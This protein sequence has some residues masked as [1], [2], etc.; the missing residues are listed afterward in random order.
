MIFLRIA[1]L[2]L[3]Q[4]APVLLAA[5]VCFAFATTGYA[6]VAVI[7]A[8][9]GGAIS[10]DNT[11]G[12]WTTLSGPVLAETAN[13]GNG[14]FGTGTIVLNAPAG[15]EFNTGAAVTVTVGRVSGSAG[16]GNQLN[17][18]GGRGS[19]VSATVTAT[20]ISVTVTQTSGSNTHNSL[21]WS[22]IQVRPT[23]GCPL[24]S[25]NMSES[26]TSSFTLSSS[27]LG[28]LTE[29]RGATRMYTVLPGQSFGACSGVTGSP[30]SQTAGVAFNLVSLVVADRW[31][32]VDT[33]Y[34]GSKTISYSGPS[35][36]NSYTTSVAFTAGMSTT[37]LAT[38]INSAQVATITATDG[39]VAGATSSSFTVSA[40]YTHYAIAVVSGTVANCDYAQVTISAHDASHNLVAPPAGRSLAIATSIGT[41]VWQGPGTVAGTGS[42]TPSGS[43]NGSATY[44][45]PG[46]ESSFTVRLR[47]SAVTSLSVN[48]NDG[49]VVEGV[50]EDPTISFVNSA[51][52]ISNGAGA[53]ATIASQIAGKASNVGF[54]AQALYLQAVRTDTN[55][56]ACTSLFPSGTD[57]TVSVGAQCN[58]PASCAQNLTLTS[59]AASSNSSVFV[60][61]GTYVTSMN[62]RFT[63][64]NAEAP[65]ALNYADAGQ[66]TLQFSAALPS[67]PAN[68]FVTGTSNAFVVRPFGFAFRGANAAAAAS[69]GTTQNSSVLAAAGDNFTMTLAAYRWASGQDANNDGIPDA[70]VDLTCNGLTPNFAATTNVSATANLPGVAT[71]A[72]SRASGAATIAA[73]EWSGGSAII[74]DWRYSEVGN[75][76]LA[77]NAASYLGDA[78]ANVSGDSG[79]DGS[80]AAGGYIG[81]FRPKQFTVS[82]A[83]LATRSDLSCAPAS[84]FSYMDEPLK[85]AFTLTAQNT[86]G[87]TTQNYTGS[88]AKLG[89]GTFSNW[90]LGAR[91]GTANLTARVDGGVAPTGSWASG[92]AA[93]T[94]TTGILRATPDN[95]DG[96]YASLGFGIAPVDP[97][98]AAMASFDFDADNNGV[99][100]RKSLGVATEMRFGRMRLDN[101]LGAEARQL[102]V[103]ML[104]EYWNGSGFV[105]NTADSCTSVP[106]STI[107]LAFATLAS[108][109]T[110]VNSDPLTFSQGLAPLVLTAPGAGNR[111]AVT[112][113][114]NLTGATGTYCTAVGAAAVATTPTATPL[115]YLRG[116]WND[117][118]D[119]D[120]NPNTW[121]DDNPGARAGFGLYGSQPGNFI[122]FRERFN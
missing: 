43:N 42:W 4:V 34:A 53:A 28:S 21:T 46:G 23:S 75:V 54:G 114:V 47:Q 26:G 44:V 121:Y 9:G 102:P 117:T 19:P 90:A 91:S 108:C 20:T 56:G 52:R 25:G 80:G 87:A 104:V 112:L 45:W 74:N 92:A 65:F 55:T 58:N 36:S 98:G 12:A 93:V 71:G 7:A 120:G 22:N 48:L 59:S 76:F 106:R 61:N 103:P 6:Q 66:I 79:M 67:P 109:Q 85:L 5:A 116:R 119:A 63:T 81:R 82:A 94:M 111:G 88:Y 8:T 62:F 13:N 77:A 110:M 60:P 35:G 97:D 29:V 118:V 37:T 38:T 57:V 115:P 2:R 40:R 15:F 84:T 113:T 96:P 101:A 122:Y 86:Q 107:A 27:N 89:I 73:A 51:F 105:T 72:I 14:A 18:G 69:H 31:G 49:T 50:G 24:A 95:P 10:A 70:G 68:Q 11:G 83:A 33:T 64:A 99:N 78:T 41:G 30:T 39:T 17:L 16:A 3:A 32:N 100:E 1:L